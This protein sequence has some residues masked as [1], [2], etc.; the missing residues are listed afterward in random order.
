MAERRRNGRGPG[1][2]HR[3]HRVTGLVSAAFVLMLAVTGLVLNHTGALRLDERYVDTAWLLD[4]YGVDAPPEPVSYEAGGRYITR[5]GRR[6]WIGSKP[7][8]DDV[9]RLSGVV[10]AGRFLVAALGDGLALFTADGRLVERLGDTAGV[11]P[12]VRRIGTTP[13]GAVVVDTPDG[14][15]RADPALT[16]WQPARGAEVAWSGPARPP[17]AAREALA[18]AWRG[19]GLSIERVL[20]DL[21]SGRLLGR[22]GVWLMDAMAVLFVLLAAT[23]IWVWARRRNSRRNGGRRGAR[24]G[25]LN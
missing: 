15:Y 19:R 7:V 22:Y 16:A 13:D 24:A 2:W 14:D 25:R 23:G 8:L 12:G 1:A 9:E 21:H 17:A 18:E 20:L 6:L 3:I 5:M 10:R 11:P 4:W